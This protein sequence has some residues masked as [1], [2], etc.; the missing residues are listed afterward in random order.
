MM[1]WRK[2]VTI[3][4]NVK[5]WSWSFCIRYLKFIFD[6]CWIFFVIILCVKL[7]QHAFCWKKIWQLWIIMY[8]RPVTWQTCDIKGGVQF[9][10]KSARGNIAGFLCV[11]VLL[12]LSGLG[13][14]LASWSWFHYDVQTGLT[15][16]CMTKLYCTWLL[17]ICWTWRIDYRRIYM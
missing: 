12:Y 10:E 1:K 16:C 14:A 13:F 6:T 5:G 7:Q 8:P 3:V 17:C 11:L 9:Y 4:R 15:C 2:K